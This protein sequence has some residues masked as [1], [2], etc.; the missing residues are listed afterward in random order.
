MV[1]GF[2]CAGLVLAVLPLFI[3][4]GKAYSEGVETILNVSL[5]S[6]R[7]E[8]LSDF[9]DE[10]YWAVGELAKH[11]EIISDSMSDATAKYQPSSA[12]D[13]SEWTENPTIETRL[14]KYF[15]SEGDFNK[16]T[17]TAKRIVQLLAQLLKDQGK[18]VSTKHQVC[19]VSS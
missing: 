7:D 15:G 19:H 2:E 14:K 8:E 9:Y 12:L 13:L 4:A 6:R 10:F 5:R 1:T 11:I 3:E 16:F 17:L 18:Y